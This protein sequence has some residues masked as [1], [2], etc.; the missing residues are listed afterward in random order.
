MSNSIQIKTHIIGSNLEIYGTEK[1]HQRLPQKLNTHR[2]TLPE[3][4]RTCHHMPLLGFT[5]GYLKPAVLPKWV[6]WVWVQYWIF[7]GAVPNGCGCGMEAGRDVCLVSL[8]P[9]MYMSD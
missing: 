2:G 9:D 7:A 5:M 1:P 3:T 6:M 8:R 4:R